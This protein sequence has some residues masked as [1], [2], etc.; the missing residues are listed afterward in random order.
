MA[1]QESGEPTGHDSTESLIDDLIR[2]ILNDAAH[3]GKTRAGAGEPM[4]SLIERT[5]MSAGTAAPRSSGLERLLL[6]QV[7]ASS[8][9]D[10]LAPALAEALTPEILKALEQHGSAGRGGRETASAGGPARGR[11]KT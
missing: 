9:A 7:L 3:A 6:A 5:L 10:A 11:K 1:A 8:L 4:A 2:D